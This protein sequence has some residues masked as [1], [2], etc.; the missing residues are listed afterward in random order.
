MSLILGASIATGVLSSKLLLLLG[1]HSLRLRYP[2]SVL[3][4]YLGFLGLVRLWIWYVSIRHVSLGLPDS[5]W[6]VG[7]VSL[8]SSGGGGG[9]SLRFG[10][11]GGGDSGGGGASDV[12]GENVSA[13]VA[14]SSS[15]GGGG[16]WL[17]DIDM[18]DLDL[19]D[20]GWWVLLLLGLL[21]LAICIAGGYLI[22]AAPQILPDAACQAL[23]T[24]A[25]LRLSKEHHHGWM[26]GVCKA[27]IL[28]LIVILG[29]ATA[30]GW[31]A[32]STCPTAS[33][34]MEVLEC[35][36]SAAPANVDGPGPS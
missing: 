28:P 16:S 36:N 17:P 11:F 22:W 27:T 19:G 30:L 3:A 12:W 21:L 15:G 1:L 24:P 26:A 34:L 23:I 9:G 10:G 20:D 18:P 31:M 6:S 32:H 25:L 2:V 29:L 8:P 14:Q 13:S 35:G 4:S 33:R 7:D 5:N